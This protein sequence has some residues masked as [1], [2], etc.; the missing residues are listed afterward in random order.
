M[1][2]SI[3]PVNGTNLFVEDSA[4]PNLPVM[5]CLHSLFL[6]SRMFEGQAAVFAGQ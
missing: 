3:I 2:R 4:Q 6:D 1:P 5:L